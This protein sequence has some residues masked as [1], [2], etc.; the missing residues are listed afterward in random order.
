MHVKP[1]AAMSFGG[2]VRIARLWAG[3]EDMIGKVIKVGGWA[4]N[5]RS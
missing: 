3:H 5:T 4:K 1:V 2:R